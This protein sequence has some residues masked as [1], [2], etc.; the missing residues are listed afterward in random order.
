MLSFCTPEMIKRQKYYRKIVFWL[1]SQGD[2]DTIPIRN[3]SFP[4][5]FPVHFFFAF[6]F[7]WSNPQLHSTTLT[8]YPFGDKV[9]LTS[10]TILLTNK[11]MRLAYYYFGVY[12]LTYITTNHGE[13][14]KI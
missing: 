4:F 6:S 9:T 5:Y 8:K 11:I 1:C 14:A 2:L 13:L 3:F 12:P 7:C 10:S